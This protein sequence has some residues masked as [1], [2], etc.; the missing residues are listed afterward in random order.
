MFYGLGNFIYDWPGKINERWN[1][2]YVV[3][4]NISD[5]MDFEIIP[6]KQGNEQAGVFHLN[7]KETIGF[8]KEIDRL[9]RIISDD[10]ELEKEFRNY[11]EKV[12]PMYDAFIE[13]YWGK[14]ITALQKR[15]LFPKMMSK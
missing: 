3:R 7:K 1:K 15:G 4:F 9:N 5:E 8:K 11:C 2:G 13:P 14:Y 6:L 12:Y 10:E